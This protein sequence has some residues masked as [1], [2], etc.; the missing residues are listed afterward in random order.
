[1]ISSTF[2]A[3]FFNVLNI[4]VLKIPDPVKQAAQKE[5]IFSIVDS[6]QLIIR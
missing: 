1:M 5:I 4:P 2:Y 6:C 3:D